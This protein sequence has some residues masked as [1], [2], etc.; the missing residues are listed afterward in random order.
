MIL[1][2]PKVEPKKISHVY[3]HIIKV[4]EPKKLSA[5]D[6]G[7]IDIQ[8]EAYIYSNA[9]QKAYCDVPCLVDEE[10]EWVGEKVRW[11]DRLWTVEQFKEEL[12]VVSH[13]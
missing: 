1:K 8:N 4:W 2:Q 13:G 9:E 6:H 7:L 11:M 5:C 10:A 3:K 12:E